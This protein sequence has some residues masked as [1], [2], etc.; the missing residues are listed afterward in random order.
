MRV[1]PVLDLMAG[2]AVHARRGR[3]TAYRPIR[4]VLVPADRAGD[5]LGLARAFRETLGVDEWYVADLDALTGAA[6]QRGLVRALAG[7]GGRLLVDAAAATP[8]R[9]QD[10]LADGA[11]RVVVGLETLP[12]FAALRRIADTIGRA[13]LVFSL[14]LRAGRPVLR[15]GTRH[16]GTPLALA[17]AAVD[18][19]AAALLVL[20]LARVGRRCG[21][22]LELVGA[23]RRAH[24][25]VELLAGGGIRSVGDLERLAAA[26][27]DGALVAT[28]LHE[29]GLTRAHLE[30]VRH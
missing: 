10:T 8:D 29:G 21:V 11:A 3:R 12:S 19:G 2:Q 7:L 14:D 1:I 24:A 4:S 20:D 25:D 9:A 5:P 15:P 6:P 22:N 13:R 27:C 30:G 26:G 28:A 17:R 23:V 18:A 16:H